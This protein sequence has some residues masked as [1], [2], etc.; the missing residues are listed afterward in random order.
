M[1][2]ITRPAEKIETVRSQCDNVRALLPFYVT[3]RLH[4]IDRR[5]V[6]DALTQNPNLRYELQI[7]RRLHQGVQHIGQQRDLDQRTQ[8]FIARFS[9]PE[10]TWWQRLLRIDRDSL[11]FWGGGLVAIPGLALNMLE[12]SLA[13]IGTAIVDILRIPDAIQFIQQLL[14]PAILESMRTLANYI[15]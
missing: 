7:M 14:T 4:P 2:E 11:V 12:V 5:V 6:D 9:K 8:I 13:E 15:V 3:D 1:P 10:P